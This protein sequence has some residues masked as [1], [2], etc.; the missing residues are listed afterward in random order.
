MASYLAYPW[1]VLCHAYPINR[2]EGIITSKVL[3]RYLRWIAK[4]WLIAT[5]AYLGLCL[6]FALLTSS[7]L[8]SGLAQSLAGIAECAQR[9]SANRCNSQGSVYFHLEKECWALNRCLSHSKELIIVSEIILECIRQ[10]WSTFNLF[11][12]LVGLYIL[13]FA[14]FPGYDSAGTPDNPGSPH[15]AA[16][17]VIDNDRPNPIPT[18][19]SMPAALRRGGISLERQNADVG[20]DRNENAE[21]APPPVH[22]PQDSGQLF[23]EIGRNMGRNMRIIRLEDNDWNPFPIGR[24]RAAPTD[25]DPLQLLDAIDRSFHVVQMNEAGNSTPVP[26][27][28]LLREGIVLPEVPL[29]EPPVDEA[30]EDRE[31]NRENPRE[32]PTI[33]DPAFGEELE[34]EVD[35]PWPIAVERLNLYRLQARPWH[36]SIGP[37]PIERLVPR[38]PLTIPILFPTTPEHH[39]IDSRGVQY[40][41]HDLEGRLLTPE[42]VVEILNGPPP[43]P[44]PRLFQVTIP[45]LEF[46]N[47]P[48]ARAH[49]LVRQMLLP[50]PWDALTN[51]D[52][53]MRL[54]QGDLYVHPPDSWER[55]PFMMRDQNHER[56]F[57]HDLG[58]HFVEPREVLEAQERVR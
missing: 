40:R 49:G 6:I 50:V 34:A 18:R 3:L 32:A 13:L 20:E 58:N 39:M 5:P 41:I 45:M 1:A 38:G 54:P 28:F 47:T 8:T 51:H 9:S 35:R 43:N 57:V 56:F 2:V 24:L 44:Q 15:H 16:E 48:E 55:S 33:N 7:L 46:V 27:Y 14:S 12:S 17:A 52:I 29:V 11:I 25:E 53:V 4:V 10:F 42:H 30:G 26:V 31:V 19:P 22:Q 37:I 23:A 36:D 21:G